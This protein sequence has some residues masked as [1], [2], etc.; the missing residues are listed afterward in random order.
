MAE[1][2]DIR[3]KFLKVV[4]NMTPALHYFDEHML[5]NVKAL[6]SRYQSKQD[7]LTFYVLVLKYLEDASKRKI[8]QSRHEIRDHG[9]APGC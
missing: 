1:I 4:Q 3:K 5:R 8:E 7:V 2:Y 6:Q 9:E